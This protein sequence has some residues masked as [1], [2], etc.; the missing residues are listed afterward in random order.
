MLGSTLPKK[1]AGP[2]NTHTSP[3]GEIGTSWAGGGGGVVRPKKLK[4]CVKL[5]LNFQMGGGDLRKIPFHGG[6]M[7]IFWNYT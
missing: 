6:N 2:E 4:K 7:D 5:Y 3:T 1:S